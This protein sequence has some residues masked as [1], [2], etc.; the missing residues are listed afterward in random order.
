M[1]IAMDVLT[2]VRSE[3]H[4]AIAAILIDLYGTRSFVHLG[5]I[6]WF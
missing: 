1:Q 3:G 4:P 2:S 5:I 6:I